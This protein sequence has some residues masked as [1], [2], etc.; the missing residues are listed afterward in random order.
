MLLASICGGCENLPL[1]REKTIDIG[2][3]TITLPKG[4]R[5][6]DVRVGG[7]SNLEF[8]PAAVRARTGDVVRFTTAD[9]RTHLIEFDTA[10]LPAAA[11]NLFATKVQLRSPPLLVQGAAWIVSLDGAPPG[12][13]TFRCQSHDT[14]GRLTVR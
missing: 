10:S 2:G 12:E 7:R 6:V 14:T 9:S 13:Y 3:D 5:V 1:R 11:K 8:E 4:V